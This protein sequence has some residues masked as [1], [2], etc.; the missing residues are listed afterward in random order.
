MA[1][2]PLAV[3]KVA[4]AAPVP[5]M[6]TDCGELAALSVST[7]F[8]VR[9]PCAAGAKV[10][11][12]VQ[13]AL[14]ASELEH[15]LPVIE[16]SELFA[17]L[18]EGAAEKLSEALPEFMIVMAWG[19]LAAPCAVVPGKL[20]VPGIRVTAGDG[21]GGAMPVPA[22]ETIC[23][24]PAA[25]SVITSIAWLAPVAV[26]ANVSETVQ[27]VP[28]ARSGWLVQLSISEKGVPAGVMARE[29]NASD[30]FPVLEIV[31]V[32]V[33]LVWPLV[34]EPKSNAVGV[35]LIAGAETAWPAGGIVHRNGWNERAGVWFRVLTIGAPG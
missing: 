33:P 18:K 28:G 29:F 25:L 9:T 21:G 27:E 19:A 12:T 20:S 4:A 17:P 26:G 5:L 3:V 22:R 8:T 32:S 24:L 14:A 13:E 23:G 11:V 2:E 7:R 30:S 6:V 34:T 10:I 1:L 35:T 31:T 15:V 16:K